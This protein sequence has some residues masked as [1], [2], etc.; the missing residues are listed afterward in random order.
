MPFATD[1]GT[2]FHYT[3]DRFLSQR[4]DMVEQTAL[5]VGN[6]EIALIVLSSV[7]I[8]FFTGK[9]IVQHFRQSEHS[10]T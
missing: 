5:A 6:S 7:L 1:I 9:K 3:I 10:P 4:F 8:M 2:R